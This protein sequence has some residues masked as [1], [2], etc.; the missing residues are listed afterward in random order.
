[1]DIDEADQRRMAVIAANE[2]TT[3]FE[4]E[5]GL[6]EVVSALVGAGIAIRSLRES[7]ELPWPRWPQMLPAGNGFWRLPDNQPRLP[8]FYALLGEKA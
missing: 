2:A 4:W 3:S 6:G 7:D 8:M 1:M 5:H